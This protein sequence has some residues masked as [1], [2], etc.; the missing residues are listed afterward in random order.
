MKLP[1]EIA[2]ERASVIADAFRDRGCWVPARSFEDNSPEEEKYGAKMMAVYS[3]RDWVGTL[4]V[5]ASGK[6]RIWGEAK[7]MPLKK[8]MRELLTEMGLEQWIEPGGPTSTLEP[9]FRG[10]PRRTSVN[11]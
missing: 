4:V 11:D 3:P 2:F 8:T 5:F 6:I 9:L 10:D 1:V 7:A